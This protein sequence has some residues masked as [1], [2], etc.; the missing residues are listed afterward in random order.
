VL[1]QH[2]ARASFQEFYARTRRLAGGYYDLKLR[3][4]QSVWTRQI[5][6][7]HTFLQHLTPPVFFTINTLLDA[8]LIGIGQKLKVSLMMVLVRYISAWETLRLKL[9]GLSNRV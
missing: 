6:F 9:G 1:V 3:Q 2:P 7:L 4:A 8:R 5:I